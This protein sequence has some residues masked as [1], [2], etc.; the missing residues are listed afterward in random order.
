VSPAAFE[1]LF[2]RHARA[3]HVTVRRWVCDPE[4]AAEI[5]QEAGARVWRI[6]DR[7]R[8]DTAAAYLYRTALNLAASK[9]RWQRIRKAS[10][11][12]IDRGAEV[13]APETVVLGRERAAAVRAAIEE[14]PADLRRVVQLRDVAELGYAEIARIL[15]IK[16]G[17]V[18]S[19][20]NTALT[21]L[22]AA[23]AVAFAA[24]V[25]AAFALRPPSG[26]T[27]DAVDA[28]LHDVDHPA[29]VGW[30]RAPAQTDPTLDAVQTRTPNV[31]M[32]RAP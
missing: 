18:G 2:V 15:D 1:A 24:A 4:D 7:L 25:V 32:Y 21:R 28:L 16:E 30:G 10:A 12:K 22:R 27:P 9:R 20:R 19:R 6:R 23:L 11:H 29:L 14:L 3:L 8:A 13:D 17:T 5:V 26:A 31:R